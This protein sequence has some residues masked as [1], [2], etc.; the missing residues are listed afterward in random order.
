M[1][2]GYCDTYH[3]YLMGCTHVTIRG[4]VFRVEFP[5]SDYCEH[6]AS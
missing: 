2:C 6:Y 5:Q 1:G 4:V 3:W